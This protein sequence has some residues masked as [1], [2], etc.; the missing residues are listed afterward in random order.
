MP[1]PTS[2]GKGRDLRLRG[3]AGGRDLRELMH[4]PAEFANLQLQLHKVTC[5][6]MCMNTGV[7]PP[8]MLES[9]IAR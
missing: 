4:L 8:E 1:G 3:G 9:H 6:H 2:L 5:T 7:H